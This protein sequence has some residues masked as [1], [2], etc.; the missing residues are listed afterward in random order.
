MSVLSD[1]DIVHAINNKYIIIVDQDGKNI[2]TNNIKS[3]S[4]DV[5]LGEHFYRLNKNI[6]NQP[7]DLW[8]ESQTKNLFEEH[9][10]DFDEET[11]CKFIELEP[12]ENILAHT[13]EFIGS[14]NNITQMVKARSSL[15]RFNITVC[16]DA[17]W[18]DV[19]YFNRYT[20]EITNNNPFKVK[21]RCHQRIAQIIFLRTG[22]TNKEYDGKYSNCVFDHVKLVVESWK[23]S[24]MLPKLHKD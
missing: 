16:R 3:C 2:S 14:S 8:S 6:P 21:L 7:I 13:N 24:D 12:N 5:T 22:Q 15:G 20:L 1:S 4:V 18:G 23:P 19:G 17:G 10:A 9:I 11:N